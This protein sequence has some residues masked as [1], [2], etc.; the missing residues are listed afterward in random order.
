MEPSN[1]DAPVVRS[2][3]PKPVL[4]AALTLIGLVVGIIVYAKGCG[5]SS[6][7]KDAGSDRAPPAAR[8]VLMD[9]CLG[10][11]GST[12]ENAH[13][14]WDAVRTAMAQ[15]A[16]RD[17]AL[18][19]LAQ[20]TAGRPLESGLAVCQTLLMQAPSGD[21]R[22]GASGPI[23]PSEVQRVA[24]LL[25]QDADLR[26]LLDDEYRHACDGE[27]MYAEAKVTEP[28]QPWSGDQR[29][30][31]TEECVQWHRGSRSGQ[32]P[33]LV[34]PPADA[35]PSIPVAP[36]PAEPAIPAC[37]TEVL[38]THHDAIVDANGD[39]ERVLK[40]ARA[41]AGC[42]A[43]AKPWATLGLSDADAFFDQFV[44]PINRKHHWLQE[45]QPDLYDAI[46]SRWSADG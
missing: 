28:S 41:L 18:P 44:A 36:P 29:E 35:S 40:Y 3:R 26:A 33:A 31:W 20:M 6:D 39:H 12:Q 13:A 1:H 5:G 4:L 19:G 38:R 34:P 8:T 7:T 24:W 42:T 37:A 15:Y 14:R 23:E 25:L 32:V 46:L 11:W 22:A 16:E 21:A 10:L 45:E 27:L 17:D 9:A 2:G 30:A 43:A